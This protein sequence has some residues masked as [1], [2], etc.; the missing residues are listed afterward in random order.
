MVLNIK[1]VMQQSIQLIAAG[2]EV[3]I[4]VGAEDVRVAAAAEETRGSIPSK[5]LLLI[6]EGVELQQIQM[7]IW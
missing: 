5:A 3:D 4:M 7:E 1:A 2:V 6:R